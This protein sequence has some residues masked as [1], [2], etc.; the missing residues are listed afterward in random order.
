MGKISRSQW[1]NYR[2]QADIGFFKNFV[3]MVDMASFNIQTNNK[4]IIFPFSKKNVQ[5][6]WFLKSEFEKKKSNFATWVYLKKVCESLTTYNSIF[7]KAYKT[8]LYALESLKSQNSNA[9][10]EIA[11]RTV[12]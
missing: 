9:G 1:A 8:C 10:L 11:V 7:F 6:F 2:G 5:R 4:I 3:F 12:V